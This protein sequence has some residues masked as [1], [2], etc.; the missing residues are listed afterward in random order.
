[1]ALLWAVSHLYA[2]WSEDFSHPLDSTWSGSLQSFQIN[3]NEKLQLQASQSGEASLWHSASIFSEMEWNFDFGLDFSP[4]S[5]N[6]LVFFLLADSS[7]VQSKQALTLEIGESGNGD[8]WRIYWRE[9]TNKTLWAEGTVGQFATGPLEFKCSLR[10]DKGGSW[11][12]K[13]ENKNG[14]LTSSTFYQ[15]IPI[16]NPQFFFGLNCIFT[17]TRKTAFYFDNF[18]VGP[19]VADVSPPSIL[20]ISKAL[21][22]QLIIRFNEEIDT[23]KSNMHMHITLEK[24]QSVLLRH[25]I[26][27]AELQLDFASE[28]PVNE[29]LKLHCDSVYDLAGNAMHDTIEIF[30]LDQKFAPSYL[31]VLIS[32]IFPD[33]TPQRFLP[34]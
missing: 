10:Y 1:M 29:E 9:G 30:Y 21:P 5:S 34:E 18:Y 22:N 23:L 24:F 31:E 33:P 26:T 28:L 16:S 8:R 12:V 3:S 2:Q 27:K 7:D 4:S 32:E 13:M 20:R 19:T 17:E 14:E 25:W 15:V 11:N 6:K